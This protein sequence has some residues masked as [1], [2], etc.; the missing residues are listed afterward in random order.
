MH[1][2]HVHDESAVSGVFY[3]SVPAGAGA[4]RFDDPRG[5][6]PPF[7]RNSIEHMPVSGELLLFPPWLA[8]SVGP[9]CPPSDGELAE[10]GRAE[11]GRADAAPSAATLVS[12]MRISLSFN[13]ARG[14]AHATADDATSDFE[15]LA[16]SSFLMDRD[17]G[18]A[19][20]GHD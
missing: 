16:D 8:H 19:E 15:L 20:N 14:G 9:S 1:S 17:D 3:V 5:A 4:I 6:L 18:P 13:L 7:K 11:G 2:R 12:Q 10:G